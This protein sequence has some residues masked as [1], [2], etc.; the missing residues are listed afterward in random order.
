MRTCTSYYRHHLRTAET[1][2][3]A[4]L[5]ITL[6][7]ALWGQS[8]AQTL[9]DDLIRL[10][11]G[12]HSDDPAEQALKLRVRD[13]V[14]TAA[15]PLLANAADAGAAGAVLA[16]NLDLV[17]A[18]ARSAAEGRP[19]RVTLTEERYPT[20]YYADFALPAGRYQSLRVLLGEAAGQN[21]WCVIFPPLCLSAA[22]DAARSTLSEEEAALITRDGTG[23]VLR[24]RAAELW[25]EL[26]N[27]LA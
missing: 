9:S 6:L 8:G 16:D 7:L 10:H 19:V 5:C 22:S 3:L 4:A 17:E 23:Y 25:G 20:R 26:S 15:A 2:A 24:F 27:A 18:A 1:A 11:V 13:A 12:A 21:W 14:L